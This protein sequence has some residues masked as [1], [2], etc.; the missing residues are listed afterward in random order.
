MRNKNLL[1]KSLFIW[2]VCPPI[3][4]III[5]SFALRASWLATLWNVS[6]FCSGLLFP[7]LSLGQ[8]FTSSYPVLALGLST[9][10]S[11]PGTFS[12]ED[13]HPLGEGIKLVSFTSSLSSTRRV[14][15]ME[16]AFAGDRNPQAPRPWFGNLFL[17]LLKAVLARSW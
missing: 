14:E 11:C 3:Q 10:H 13:T 7:T 4:G 8:G 15:V 9:S 12:N 5:R 16:A 2:R 6:S 17:H 1:P